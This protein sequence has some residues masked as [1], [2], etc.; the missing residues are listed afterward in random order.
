MV[1]FEGGVLRA[2]LYTQILESH[3][4]ISGGGDGTLY[5][6]SLGMHA[7]SRLGDEDR[8]R[9]FPYVVAAYVR[10]VL[11]EENSK[12]LDRDAKVNG[13]T[14][15]GD[16]DLAS[17]NDSLFEVAQL[18]G[19]G[20]DIDVEVNAECLANALAELELLRHRLAMREQGGGA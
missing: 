17:L 9:A 15:L 4:Q 11:D 3:Q 8:T 1:E 19:K 7:W 18:I 2:G 13:K 5:T 16:H 6:V 10:E 20:I 12:L 14:Y